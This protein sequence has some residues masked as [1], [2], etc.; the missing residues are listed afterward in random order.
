MGALALEFV[1][2]EVCG[3]RVEETVAV[4]VDAV[5]DGCE[6]KEDFRE[7]PDFEGGGFM[8]EVLLVLAVK[9]GSGVRV[10]SGD[11]DCAV[12][13]SAGPEREAGV[14]GARESGVEEDRR[15]DGDAEAL[16]FGGG[17]S[18]AFELS[19]VEPVPILRTGRSAR[20]I[21]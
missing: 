18:G 15:G 21:L 8:A 14:G 5:E 19:L 12:G 3:N 17:G 4:G 11:A 2:L 16:N 1:L 13:V 9:P 6:P 7:C 10:A 20:A